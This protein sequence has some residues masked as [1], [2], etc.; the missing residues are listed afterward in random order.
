MYRHVFQKV[1]F[2]SECFAAVVA[3][4]RL[5]ARVR[6]KVD[7]DVGLVQEASVAYL[8]VVHHL[9]SLVA[10]TASS[11]TSTAASSSVRLA[12]AAKKTL[13]IEEH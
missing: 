5:L 13:Q 6:S 9:L 3:P 12:T 11:T 4:K 10:L 1:C 7:L 8:T 2:L